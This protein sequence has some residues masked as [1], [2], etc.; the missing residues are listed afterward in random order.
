MFAEVLSG[1]R[2]IELAVIKLHSNYGSNVAKCDDKGSG[3]KKIYNAWRLW[4]V[5]Q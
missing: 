5:M 2:L 4:T 1:A 3:D